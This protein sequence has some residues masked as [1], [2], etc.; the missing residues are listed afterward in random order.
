MRRACGAEPESPATPET[1]ASDPPVAG[2]SLTRAEPRRSASDVDREFFA[3]N[4]PRQLSFSLP[5]AGPLS[6]PDTLVRR[7]VKQEA[8]TQ[9]ESS[10][11]GQDAFGRSC[12][13]SRQ[14]IAGVV[15]GATANLVKSQFCFR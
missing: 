10:A 7:E 11:P 9:G 8:R 14:T 4:R 2:N 1:G 3:G 13:G 15:A 5:Q 6:A 12:T